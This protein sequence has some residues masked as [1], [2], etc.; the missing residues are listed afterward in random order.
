MVTPSY[1][2][3]LN[4]KAPPN[5]GSEDGGRSVAVEKMAQSSRRGK[6]GIQRRG[7][8]RSTG[9]SHVATS[10]ATVGIISRGNGG[11]VWRC[12]DGDGI[13]GSEDVAGKTA[14]ITRPS[15]RRR[16]PAWRSALAFCNGSSKGTSRLGGARPVQRCGYLKTRGAT[17]MRWASLTWR[18]GAKRGNLDR[19][20][21]FGFTWGD[22]RAVRRRSSTRSR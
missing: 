5:P 20:P 9:E 14:K 7:T 15:A 3:N 12:C 22:S 21:H 1:G 19:K 11:C 18:R 16:S 4:V 2:L 13:G 8:R 10:G 17:R 6:V